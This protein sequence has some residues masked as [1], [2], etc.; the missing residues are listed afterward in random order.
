MSLYYSSLHLVDLFNKLD[1]SLFIF[2]ITITLFR[3]KWFSHERV[4]AWLWDQ[5]S[6]LDKLNK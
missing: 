2:S 5:D 4:K 6:T 1:T 3:L